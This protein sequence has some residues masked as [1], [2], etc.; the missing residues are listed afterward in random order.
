[1][2][3][4]NKPTN[5]SWSRPSSIWIGL[6][7]IFGGI[8]VLLNQFD[9]LSFELNW[10]ALFIMMP[11]F[12]FLNGAYNRYRSHGNAFS[13]D[14]AFTALMGFFLTALSISLLLGAVWNINWSLFWP[15]ILV[16]IGLGMIF[17]RSQKG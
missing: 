2:E 8:A 1:M 12:G 15:V 7:F 17:S 16:L 5:E 13:M 10:W 14:V 3:E 11:A 9:L 4:Q 6:I